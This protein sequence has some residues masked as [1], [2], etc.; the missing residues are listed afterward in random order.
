VRKLGIQTMHGLSG[1]PIE[2]SAPGWTGTFRRR[3]RED[4][5]HCSP[6][7]VIRRCG[8]STNVKAQVQAG[9]RRDTLL[10]SIQVA[11]VASLLWISTRPDWRMAA[12]RRPASDAV[13]RKGGSRSQC[14]MAH[15]TTA[16]RRSAPECPV[17]GISNGK[18]L[19][20]K[21]DGARL[22]T[23]LR[24]CFTAL[25]HESCLTSLAAA[26]RKQRL[27]A[28]SNDRRFGP[29]EAAYRLRCTG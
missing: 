4:H 27:R 3:R 14:L 9:V 16:S 1:F 8:P 11:I 6:T 26:N 7:A 28:K 2:T 24:G 21:R 22:R 23:V 29:A 12:A 10:G 18:K 15:A 17:P 13:V 20:G 25:G 5:P 19:L